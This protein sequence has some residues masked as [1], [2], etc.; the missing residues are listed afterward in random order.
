[1]VRQLLNGTMHG[2][3][4]A[5]YR[6]VSRFLGDTEFGGKTGTSNNHSDAWFIGTTPRLVVGA[7]VGGEYRCIHFRTGQLGQGNRTALP[8]CGNF[9]EPVLSDPAFKHY[10]CKYEVPK[11][12]DANI[13]Q[14]GCG[15]YFRSPSDSDSIAVD[16]IMVRTEVMP[17][18]NGM[19][20]DP[21]ETGNAS[22]QPQPNEPKEAEEP[23]Q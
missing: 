3:S 8:I 22:Q 12:L 7:W 13:N 5:L 18:E 21:K 16:S 10:R 14:Y 9:L 23:K 4:S 2:T 11:D 20:T 15:G 19:A 1:M 17:D 6:W